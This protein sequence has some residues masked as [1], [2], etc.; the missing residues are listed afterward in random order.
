M[1]C[2]SGEG[3]AFVADKREKRRRRKPGHLKRGR[4]RRRDGGIVTERAV[5]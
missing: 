3:N 4:E 1:E 5:I 2:E